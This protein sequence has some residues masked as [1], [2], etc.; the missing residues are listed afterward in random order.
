M[1]RQKNNSK[2]LEFKKIFV[3]V[4]TSGEWGRCDKTRT[5]NNRKIAKREYYQLLTPEN[6][7]PFVFYNTTRGEIQ[8]RPND[9]HFY[10]INT[11][12]ISDHAEK[13]IKCY[14]VSGNQGYGVAYLDLDCH[15]GETDLEL[16]KQTLSKIINRY[17]KRDFFL[18]ILSDNGHN[19]LLLVE[20][21]KPNTIGLL[22]HKKRFNE[23]ITELNKS[24]QILFNH[25]TIETSI[26]VKGRTDQWNGDKLTA[27][28]LWKLPLNTYKHGGK[29]DGAKGFDEEY[30]EKIKTFKPL[31]LSE[32]SQLS[33]GVKSLIKFYE[34]KIEHKQIEPLEMLIE[35]DVVSLL[36]NDL[37]KKKFVKYQNN[38]L[39][40]FDDNNKFQQNLLDMCFLSR[41]LGYVPEVEE[42]LIWIKDNNRFSEPWN[43][44]ETKRE[45]RIKTCLKIVS[46]TFVKLNGRIEFDF[47]KY[48]C[49]IKRHFIDGFKI[50]DKKT[51]INHSYSHKEL[52]TYLT[53]FDFCLNSSFE[54]GGIPTTRIK[55]LL[56]FTVVSWNQRKYQ[57]IRD[58]F[59]EIGLYSI[60]RF[61]LWGY[62]CWNWRKKQM[63][64]KDAYKETK[65]K[66]E[67]VVSSKK[68]LEILYSSSIPF[69][70]HLNLIQCINTNFEIN[71]NVIKEERQ[72]CIRPP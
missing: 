26:E 11:A 49:W 36:K 54:D 7:N 4:F 12:R 20:Y 15:N 67:L 30:L 2:Y 43:L 57:L 3:D 10:K 47:T 48:E 41:K 53:L 39:D 50:F 16:A 22:K 24:L 44:R 42:A 27:G 8:Y 18:D 52:N 70:L 60:D 65:D 68:E 37:E 66:Y 72:P 62:S 25:L 14:S 6:P 1:K 17:V 34:R 69:H 64:V 56:G 51:G 32:L 5:S 59:E 61:H 58:Y 28:D 46:K 19:N 31:S 33:N 45:Q 21:N 71:E 55:A 63:P 38:D 23:L 29:N 35:T 13:D 40:K 9:E